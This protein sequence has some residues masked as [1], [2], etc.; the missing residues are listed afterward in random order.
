MTYS[1][2]LTIL[3]HMK[4]LTEKQTHTHIKSRRF[5][6]R[7]MWLPALVLIASLL[8]FWQNAGENSHSPRPMNSQC[9]FEDFYNPAL[10]YVSLRVPSL[11]YTGCAAYDGKKETGY[12]YYSLEDGTCH[13]YLLDPSFGYPDPPERGTLALNGRLI[14]L[15]EDTYESLLQAMAGSL[16]WT[17]S[18]LRNMTSPYIISALPYPAQMHEA[19][20]L[21]A[22]CA[23]LISLVDLIWLF[24]RS[25]RH[26]REPL[27]DSDAPSHIQPA[28]SQE[29]QRPLVSHR[30]KKH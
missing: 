30:R 18:S 9:N 21:L 7:Q 15:D 16:S 1:S 22:G 19:F 4:N 11:Y 26:H 10:P 8:L 23:F 17:V 12:Y 13:F 3:K 29:P 24:Y 14:R 20:L 5:Y 27:H 6:R 2:E 28:S 25:V